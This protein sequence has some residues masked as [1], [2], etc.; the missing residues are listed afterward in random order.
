MHIPFVSVVI[1]VYNDN[2]GLVRC[3]GAVLG[4]DYPADSFE[5]IVVDNASHPAIDL[6]ESNPKLPPVNLVV[7]KKPGSYAA[8]NRGIASAK[9]EVFAFTDADC[10]PAKNWLKSAVNRLTGEPR[11]IIL[12]GKISVF[13][14]VPE[15]PT[16][17][18]LYDMNFGLRQVRYVQVYGFA[19]T[20]NLIA[21]K[22]VF[23]IVGKFN[24]ELKSGGDHEW[25]MRAA[26][27]GYQIVYAPEVEIFHPA[28]RSLAAVLVKIRR[29][30][31]GHHDLRTFNRNRLAL[32]H[33]KNKR[34]PLMEESFQQLIHI[35]R[36]Y[37]PAAFF[38]ALGV[39]AT[40]AVVR[41]FER[42]RCQL[43]YY[44]LRQ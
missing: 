29:T 18:E 40:T 35:W 43:G 11:N 5:I 25:A 39:V 32:R 9:G 23:K 15:K 30:A 37:G 3:L 17:I 16:C 13:S 27:K 10:L 2:D 4:Q 33:C 21:S 42:T 20:A 41:A 6:P 26:A 31:G 22:R 24:S 38:G 19:A 44:S 28:R 34:I 36:H 12:G 1:P 8:R 14:A 7:E